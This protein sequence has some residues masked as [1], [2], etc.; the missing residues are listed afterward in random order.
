M[1]IQNGTR[2][3]RSEKRIGR[4]PPSSTECVSH[5]SGANFPM[6]AAESTLPPSDT[7]ANRPEDWK[8]MNI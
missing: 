1:L 3:M 4:S 2:I 8:L 7:C 6:I 5:E